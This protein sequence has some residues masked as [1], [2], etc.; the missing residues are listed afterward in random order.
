MSTD[1][2]LP[3]SEAESVIRLN[4]AGYR[5]VFDIVNK[6]RAHFIKTVPD[7]DATHAREIYRQAREHA[8]TLKSLFR[9]WQLRQ[10]PVIG[11]LKK[12][13][14]T[15]SP[16]LKETLLRNLGG[17]GDFSDLLARSTEY[18][19]AASIQSLF[20]PGRYA[21]ALY[22]VA[23]NLHENGSAFDINK[24]R[25]DLQNLILSETTMNQEITSLDLLLEILQGNNSDHLNALSESFFPMTLP[26]DDKLTQI[27]AALSAQGRTL[28]GI[29]DS[30]S[31]TQASS[32][33]VDGYLTRSVSSP[34]VISGQRFF[35]KT[36]GEMVW[37]SHATAGGAS[38]P[39]AHLNVGKP[40]AAAVQTAPLNITRKEGLL[41]L[42][43]DG[44]VTLNGIS[45]S[46]CYLM[47]DSGEDNGKEGPYARMGNTKGNQQVSPTRHLAITL[48]SDGNN[49]TWLKTSKGYIGVK[50]SGAADWPDALTVNEP[51]TATAL[52]FTFC[53][54]ETGD[55]TISPEAM[56]P[57]DTTPNPPARTILNLT[58]LSYQ[59]MANETLTQADIA[60]HYGLKNG[61]QRSASDLA[62]QLNDI[63]TFCQ[64]TGLT[65]NQVLEL[66]AQADYAHSATDAH[67]SCPFYKYGNT[68]REDVWK[69]GAAYLNSGL[70]DITQPDERLLWIQPEVRDTSGNITTPAALNFTDDTLVS[71]AGNAEKL[72]RL[73]NTT[74]LSFEML[75]WVIVS[76]SKAA[77]YDSPIPNSVVLR[78]LAACVDLQ[79]RYG[80]TPNTFVSFIGPVNPYARAQEKSFY[81]SLFTL[82][83]QT[84]CIPLGGN[85]KCNGDAGSYES[86]CFKALGVTSDEF[87]RIGRYCFGNV[88]RFK[89]SELT[90][91]QI[92]RFGAIPRMLG[93]TFA[94]AECLWQLMA[95]GSDALLV[96]L[97]RD[98][99]FAAIDLIRRTEQVLSW[100]ADNNLNLIQVQAMVSTVYNG[101]ATAE[102]FTFLQNV[103]HSVKGSLSADGEM[104]DALHQKVCRALA[105]GFNLKA[106]I[107]A[108][109]T[110]W[111]DKTDA[112][113]TLDRYWANIKA[114][115]GNAQN[116]TVEDLQKDTAGLVDATQRLSQLV[117]VARWLNL[118]E[119]DLML[120][121]DT[122]K[123]LDGSLPGTPQPDLPLLLLLTRFKRWQSQVTTSVDEALRLLPVLADGTAKAADVAEKIAVLHN[124]TADSVLRMNTLRF[125]NGKFPHS[126]AQL[127]SLL[128]WL[129]TGQMLN[130]GSAALHDLLTM[131]QSRVEA[132]DNV[133]IARVADTLTAGVSR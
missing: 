82:A 66:T 10:E 61:A 77:G 19:D 121:T 72:I 33:A 91:G 5:T 126:F 62:T 54:D 84:G 119:Q 48:E 95:G 15:S 16:L 4:K 14:T 83:D 52:L 133:L 41:Y 74:G 17:D 22:K 24:R 117:L 57:P 129:R 127:Y 53:K 37:L 106:N 85:V 43:I 36:E 27:N 64:K 56:L 104:D 28:N 131:A 86:A 67:N 30:L 7:I 20:S 111:L 34:E 46:G 114:F 12:L 21:A 102:M 78:A 40:L 124:L 58:P 76:A 125:G 90:A 79:E 68:S 8:E 128:T 35:L 107:M 60:S 11:G 100:M 110:K 99:G 89:M 71:L 88:D 101:T 29:W 97:G 2:L 75:D 63:P 18:T 93:L 23:R 69:Y 9:S 109:V 59:L 32:F 44:D 116:T 65:F 112:S 6:S 51:T 87:V 123:Q 73:R 1:N 115:F 31:D 113:F 98:T 70:D 45:L 120:L 94:E 103:Y 50:S 47:A 81:E 105:G 130:V 80:I 132:E 42:G 49:G 26:Y 25:P 108:Q 39:G 122:P 55:T 38:L 96:A 92:Y 13:T 118:S 3:V